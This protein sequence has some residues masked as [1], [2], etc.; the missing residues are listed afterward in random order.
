MKIK[1]MYATIHD[2]SYGGYPYKVIVMVELPVEEFNKLCPKIGKARPNPYGKSSGAPRDLGGL[3]ID[4]NNAVYALNS[5]IPAHN[6]SIDSKGSTRAKN[7]IKT[8]EFVYFF[9]DHNKAERL[10][11]EVFRHKNGEVL[12][13][14]FQCIDIMVTK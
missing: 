9:S 4:V 3:I 14:N 5:D 6:P 1:D 13:K 2:T 7:G 10:G 8:L 12:A 11:F